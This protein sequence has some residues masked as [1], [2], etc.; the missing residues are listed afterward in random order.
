MPIPEMTQP[1]CLFYYDHEWMFKQFLLKNIF[2]FNLF[3][4]RYGYGISDEF[5]SEF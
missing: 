4:F 2:H 5:V 3:N 1:L